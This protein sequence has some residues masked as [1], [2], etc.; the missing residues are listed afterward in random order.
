[1][2]LRGH[3]L[4]SEMWPRSSTSRATSRSLLFEGLGRAALKLRRGRA[5]FLMRGECLLMEG[6]RPRPATRV[7]HSVSCDSSLALMA[8]AW[9]A[10]LRASLSS[11]CFSSSR[12]RPRSSRFSDSMQAHSFSSSLMR[13]ARTLLDFARSRF[14]RSIFLRTGRGAAGS[15]GEHM[16]RAA[17]GGGVGGETHAFRCCPTTLGAR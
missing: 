11:T 16:E 2:D 3:D 14:W 6:S 17:R 5:G 15:A 1:M 8:R 7:P 4:V 12:M 10:I 9:S 13:R